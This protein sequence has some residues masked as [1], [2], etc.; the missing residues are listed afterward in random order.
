MFLAFLLDQI[1][2]RFDNSFKKALVFA[3]S[4]IMLWQK[5][6]E[7]FNLIQVNTMDNIYKIIAK[8]IKLSVSIISLA[9]AALEIIVVNIMHITLFM[10][11]PNVWLR[12]RL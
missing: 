5:M 6:R 9:I 4:K 7:I 12:G 8:E 11:V 3:K 1:Q 2:Q 10:V